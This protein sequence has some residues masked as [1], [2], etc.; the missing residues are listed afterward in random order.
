MSLIQK[1]SKLSPCRVFAYFA[2]KHEFRFLSDELYLKLLYRGQ[3]GRKLRLSNPKRF[4]ELLQWMKI[5]D[6]KPRYTAMVDKA[7]AK[8]WAAEIIG[9]EHIIPT[10]GV[11]EHFDDIDFDSLPDRFVLKCTHDSHSVVICRDRQNFDYSKAKQILE[12]ALK[13]EYYYE[14]R[15]WPYKNVPPRII[16]EQYIENEATSDLRD[17]KFFTFNGVPKVMY[18]ATGRGAGE[19]YG[20]FF[21]MEF[22]HL[23]LMI[24]HQMAPVCPEKPALFDEMKQAAQLLAQGTPQVR[25]DFYEANGQFYFG[26][27]T[28]FHCGGFASFHPDE[29]DEIFGSWIR[30]G[31][32]IDEKAQ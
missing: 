24:D 29:W 14:G 23:D 1:I 6:R 5:Y 22:N 13:K 9:Q 18:I 16:A 17:Y 4:T 20:D 30:E 15:Q 28:F 11:W 31:L 21:D 8:Q 25:A 19:T 32:F 10:L 2:R 3:T 12:T 7:A 26:E 27:M